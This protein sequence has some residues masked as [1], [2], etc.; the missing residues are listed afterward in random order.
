MYV[1][2]G[3]ASLARSNISN[4]ISTE[5]GGGLYSAGGRTSLSNGT[6][7]SGCSAPEGQGSSIFL[8]AGEVS[9]TLPTPAGRWLPN[10]RC[11]VYREA[12]AYA[13]CLEHRG[14]CALAIAAVGQPPWYCPEPTVVQP[15]NWD[16]TRGGDPSLLGK[17]I[18]QLPLLPVDQDFPF[19]C[20]AGILGSADP[21]SQSSSACAGR[22]PAGR[23]CP[24]EATFKALPC[25]A[26]H[27]CPEGTSV[28]LPCR[29]GTYSNATDLVAASD[30]T[31]ADPGY[32]ATTG[33]TQQTACAKG[34]YTNTSIV[35]KDS[36]TLCDSGTYQDKSGMAACKPC[37]A[38]TYAASEGLSQCIPCPYPLSSEV[39]GVICSICKE[40]FYLRNSSAGPSDIFFLTESCQPC[41]RYATCNTTG[42]TLASLGV[43][44]GYWR[45]S[46]TTS[47]LYP[48]DSE[49]C[50]G[51]DLRV[52]AGLQ[53][54]RNAEEGNDPYCTHGHTGPLCE[55]CVAP[56]EYFSRA[57]GQCVACPSTGRTAVVA[58]VS[59]C[60]LA[61]L[62][63]TYAAI[64]RR[65]LWR[66]ADEAGL[67]PKF[68]IIVSFYQVSS[69][70]GVVYGVR[71]D[72]RFTIWLNAFSLDVF[73][74]AI[75]GS[76]LG[77]MTSRLLIAGLWPYVAV[78]LVS[79]AILARSTLF[80]LSA[81]A[82]PR[83]AVRQA[84][85]RKTLGL[86][87]YWAIFLFYLVLP[88]VSR[89]IFS[90]ILCRS[91]GYDDASETRISFLLADTSLKCNAGPDWENG[92]SEL[93]VYFWSFF[94]LWPVLVPV[95]FLTLLLRVR[96]PVTAQRATPL[97][98]ATSFLW[99][100]YS[101]GFLFWE[102][103]GGAQC[104]WRLAISREPCTS[105]RI[106]DRPDP[107][108]LSHLDGALHRSAERLGQASAPRRRRHRLSD[109]CHHP[110][111]RPPLPALRQPLPCVPRQLAAH[112]LL[113]R[114]A[115]HPGAGHT[116]LAVRK[117]AIASSVS[118]SSLASSAV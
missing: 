95:S 107:Q 44:P 19:A 96:V 50:V 39:S 115:G 13:A 5:S 49:T 15:C 71:L 111:P 29:A 83:S 53:V 78:A 103:C 79:L 9:Y 82:D 109:V 98:T 56:S 27:Y 35:T 32:I 117:P 57:R 101:A 1:E 116:P 18:Y 52:G 7:I 73:E 21:T 16:S 22:C 23:Q 36:C 62:A 99:R 113:L 66:R 3:S 33:A 43:A 91:F 58:L 68:K 4:C 77:G 14:D 70:L 112:L 61:I 100:D 20:A 67:Q 85:G 42:T 102:V 37:E 12:C 94:G 110:R 114:G 65:R 46:P 17:S 74:L 25:D 11:E 41:P 54:P 51:S 6:L 47:E 40:G 45:A 64:R 31:D 48:C 92:S 55:G 88:S 24:E 72:E 38:G 108:D 28:P 76:C 106:G 90:A 87:L 80:N 2:T 34:S 8:L 10:A 30:C 118:P 59:A 75:P 93:R 86:L 105:L 63:G 26:G 89:S 60:A 84:F 97:S 69:T 81:G 104:G